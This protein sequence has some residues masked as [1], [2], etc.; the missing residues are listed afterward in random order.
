MAP[1]IKNDG[2]I[3]NT[4]N[5]MYNLISALV[6]RWRPE[7]HTF[8]LSCGECTVTLEDVAFQLGLPINRSVATDVRS[9]YPDTERSSTVPI[10]RLMIEQYVREGSSGVTGI[11]YS[12]SFVASS[13]SESACKWERFTRSTREE[14]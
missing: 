7:T 9:F 14:T 5:N 13:I 12:S 10:Y 4:V 6:K 3:S 1:L 8:Y 2:H 11:E